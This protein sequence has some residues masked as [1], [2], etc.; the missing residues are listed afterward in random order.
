MSITFIVHP[1]IPARFLSV[2]I[3]DH[4]TYDTQ[5]ESLYEKIALRHF[6]AFGESESKMI[7]IGFMNAM[8]MIASAA[9]NAIAR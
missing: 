1:T 6:A 3:L 8:R 5:S 7:F 2:E 4:E 9:T